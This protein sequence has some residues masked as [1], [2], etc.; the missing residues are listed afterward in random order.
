V[1]I[2][3]KLS[4]RPSHPPSVVFQYAKCLNIEV[5][6]ATPGTNASYIYIYVSE[7]SI[8][9]YYI[10]KYVVASMMCMFTY[11]SILS[12]HKLRIRKSRFVLDDLMRFF[13]K[14][15]MCR[16]NSSYRCIT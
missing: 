7:S 12:D 10:I 2:D 15:S 4:G 3:A 16:Q 9:V 8:A 11:A 5:S 6:R 13:K 1:V 14:G